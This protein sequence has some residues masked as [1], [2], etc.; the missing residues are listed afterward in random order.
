MNFSRQ[1]GCILTVSLD[2]YHRIW[3]TEADLLGEFTLPNLT[4]AMKASR[5]TTYN[6]ILE[7]ET[8]FDIT[9]DMNDFLSGLVFRPR[10]Y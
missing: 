5:V 2:G 8:F 7:I 9:S 1:T 6:V 4:D 3:N 10:S